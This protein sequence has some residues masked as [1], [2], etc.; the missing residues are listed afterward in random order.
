VV[1]R[2]LFRCLIAGMAALILVAGAVLADELVGRVVEV[3]S[4]AKKIVVEKKETNDRVTVTITDQTVLETPTGKEI[5]KIDLESLNRRFGPQMKSV[6]VHHEG[7][8]AS[9]IV[10]KAFMK[11]DGD[12]DDEP[13]ERDKP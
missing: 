11:Q 5:R 3:D 12:R 9:R 2:S 4:A 10:L 1:R 6:V 13:K 8:V 7:G